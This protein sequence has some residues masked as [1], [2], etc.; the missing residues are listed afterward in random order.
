MTH[1]F[2]DGYGREPFRSLV[3]QYPG[4]D[5]YRP[6]DFRTEWGPVFHRGR[7]DGTARVLVI[8]QAGLPKITNT[9]GAEKGR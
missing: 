5:V 1:L 3:E 9:R 7:L 6:Q 8:G 2:D 4:E